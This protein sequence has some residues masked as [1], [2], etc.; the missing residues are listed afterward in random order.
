MD[1]IKNKIITISGE[2]RSG[3]STV[4]TQL[5]RRYNELGYRVH[6]IETGKLFREISEAEYSKMYPEK[7]DI[8]QADI[9]DDE[10]FAKKR[11]EIDSAIDGMI[12]EKG[13]EINSQERPSDVY[14]IDSRLAWHN[15]PDS[16]AV[17]LTVAEKIAGQRAFKDKS[18]GSK[19]S[20]DTIEEATEKTK[21]R[22]LGEV[23]RYKQRYGVDLTDP[24]NYDL[25]VDTSYSDTLEL[26]NIII[27]GEKAYREE[28]AYP[29]TWAS[30]LT[31]L[32]VQKGR[33]TSSESIRGNTIESL[34]EVIKKEGYDPIKGTLDMAEEDGVKFLLEGNH[35]TMAAL[36]AGKT[37][38]PYD[39]IYK[40]NQWSKEAAEEVYSD[41]T[42]ERIYDWIE[43]IEYCGRKGQIEQLKGVTVKDLISAD[44]VFKIVQERKARKQGQTTDSTSR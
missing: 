34:A 21:Q 24:K 27:E 20:Y 7:T 2:P 29:K 6:V 41:E 3:K 1:K 25:I 43:Y 26:A 18:K 19:D 12:A 39:V 11:A 15:I 8:K 44:K 9:Q 33:E 13:R 5:V 17:R 37:L 32:T 16:Y 23:R 40:D 38:L 14:I 42:N 22:T 31:F 35:R 30:P 28:K 4:V 36:V 10:T